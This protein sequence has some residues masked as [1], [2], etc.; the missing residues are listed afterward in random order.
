MQ[1]I[2]ESELSDGQVEIDWSPEGEAAAAANA[3]Q[4]SFLDQAIAATGP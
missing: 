4:E 2:H 3:P 1:R